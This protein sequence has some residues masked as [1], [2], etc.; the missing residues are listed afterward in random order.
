[1][2]NINGPVQRLQNS[3]IQK[4][5]VAKPCREEASCAAQW[6]QGFS[7]AHVWVHYGTLLLHAPQPGASASRFQAFGPF[8]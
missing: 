2:G 7:E 4:H 6:S 8:F 5:A 3:G 1:M